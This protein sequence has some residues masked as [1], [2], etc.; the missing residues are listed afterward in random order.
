[1]NHAGLKNNNKEAERHTPSICRGKNTMVTNKLG[2]LPIQSCENQIPDNSL[3]ATNT[4]CGHWL[5]VGEVMNE[6]IATIDAQSSVASA[7]RIMSTN[8]MSCL[9]VSCDGY[10][11]GIVTE[12][13]ILKKV[14]MTH[15]TFHR[16]RVEQIMSS[17]IR[18][19]PYNSTIMDASKIMEVENIRRLVVLKEGQPVGIITQTDMVRVLASYTA[20][21]EVSEI[22]RKDAVVIASSAT[23]RE[24]AE[25]MASKDISCLVV[26]ENGTIVG[27]FTERDILKRVVALNENPGKIVLNQVMSKPVVTIPANYSLLS[28]TK[29]LERAGIRRLVVTEYDTLLGVITQTDIHRALTATLQDKEQKYLRLL[30]ESYNSIFTVDA[31]L[32]TTYVNHA[33]MRLLDVDDTEEL[34][35]KVFLPERFWAVPEQRDHLMDQLKKVG[36]VVDELSLK[37][38]KG[39]TLSVI[40]FIMPN[41]D[42]TGQVNGSHGILY[43]TN[44]K[45]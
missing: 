37:T 26:T 20:S 6:D 27:I 9:I 31:K 12:T 45:E 23:V 8:K 1:M 40:L 25:L 22:L 29:L 18:S 34:I 15:H 24:A 21:I 19:I 5:E 13:D 36:V 35:G 17:P 43:N 16:I 42:L 10:L 2:L 44:A 3:G 14:A 4:A 7:A 39:S 30:T 32:T 33:F 11:S 28:A 38:A 41:K